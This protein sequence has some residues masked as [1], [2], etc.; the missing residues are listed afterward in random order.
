M[1]MREPVPERVWVFDFDGTL[2]SLVADRGAAKLLPEARELLSGL[3]RLPRQV[4]AVL[5][6]RRLDDLA[7]RVDFRGLYL[8]GGSGAEWLLPG[9][10][11]RTADSKTRR[12]RHIRSAVLPALERLR[13]IPGVDLE[14]KHWSVAVHVRQAAPDEKPGVLS[15][16][17]SLVRTTGIRLLR[18]PEVFEILLLP[19][20]DKLFGAVV[21]CEMLRHVPSPGSLVYA[22]DDENDA[23]AMAWVIRNGGIALSVGAEILIPGV[24]LV[25]GPSAL[26]REVRRLAGLDEK[27]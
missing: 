16:L 23:M 25:D 12:L 11:R 10:E 8:G 3:V 5:S 9:G 21:L 27:G 4:T 15:F 2:S 7:A 18:G 14:D 17:E 6:S 13:E 22:G 19:E 20:I 24:R 1:P 26:V